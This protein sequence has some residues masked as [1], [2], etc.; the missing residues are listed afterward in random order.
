MWEKECIYFYNWVLCCTAEIERKLWINYNFF[1]KKKI[2]KNLIFRELT[3][4]ALGEGRGKFYDAL[5]NFVHHGF[6]QMGERALR[7]YCG[8]Y[9]LLLFS[10]NKVFLWPSAFGVLPLMQP[11][12]IP[13]KYTPY[14]FTH[15]L[16]KE[17][18][19]PTLGSIQ[20]NNVTRLRISSVSSW[21]LEKWLL[22]LV[23]PF[24][25]WQVI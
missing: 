17:C 1:E 10:K 8:I 14:C 2:Y 25:R 16:D 24:P 7:F 23:L 3:L 5:W 15:H 13:L 11:Q 9:S 18:V 21:G 22:H 20:G 12:C 4:M 19:S 6:S